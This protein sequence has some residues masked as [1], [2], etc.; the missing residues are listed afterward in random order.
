MRADIAAL[1]PV[2]GGKHS[3]FHHEEGYFL[4][5]EGQADISAWFP[6]LVTFR[7][8]EWNKKTFNLTDHV[9]QVS[10]F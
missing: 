7:K 4:I 8:L 1:L 10:G 5:I 6:Q 9:N 2:L 3:V